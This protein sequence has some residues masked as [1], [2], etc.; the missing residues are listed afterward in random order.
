MC[1]LLNFYVVM[2]VNSHFQCEKT[3][4]PSLWGTM[5]MNFFYLITECIHR[6]TIGI[7]E[8]RV[9]T[10]RSG[11]VGKLTQIG[12]VQRVGDESEDDH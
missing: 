8:R 6:Q 12:N 9:Q 10:C 1:W 4:C 11:S 3:L 7:S 5:N 2:E